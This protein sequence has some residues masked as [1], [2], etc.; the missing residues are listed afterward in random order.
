[1]QDFFKQQPDWLKSW[2]ESQE[3]L[4]KQFAGLSEEWAKNIP[5]GKKKDPDFFTADYA[6]FTDKAAPLGAPSCTRLRSTS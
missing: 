2:Q 1:M 3:T 6:D 5:G 4:T